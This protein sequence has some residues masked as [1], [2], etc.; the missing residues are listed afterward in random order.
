MHPFDEVFRSDRPPHLVRVGDE[1]PDEGLRLE[2][3]AGGRR[4]VVQDG[5][6][7]GGIGLQLFAQEVGKTVEVPEIPRNHQ[8]D[9]RLP[10]FLQHPDQA[11]VARPFPEAVQAGAETV[12]E[13]HHLGGAQERLF[14]VDGPAV[15]HGVQ[16]L[17]VREVAADP[18][19]LRFVTRLDIVVIEGAV[20]VEGGQDAGCQEQQDGQQ[21]EAGLFFHRGLRRLRMVPGSGSVPGSIAL[22]R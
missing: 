15:A 5:G 6:E 13:F 14:I 3:V 7:V 12:A 4:R 1:H 16:Q 20:E 10:P 22:Y 18:D 21:A 11:F 17:V 8:P 9:R 2:S 19:V